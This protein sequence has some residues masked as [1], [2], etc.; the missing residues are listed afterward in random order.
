MQASSSHF[1][2]HDIVQQLQARLAQRADPNYAEWYR[3]NVKPTAPVRGVRMQDLRHLVMAWHQ[4]WQ[5]QQA[6]APASLQL[7]VTFQLFN[8]DHV[9]DRLAAMVFLD[10]VL[11]PSKVV[12]PELLP[13]LA[14]LF[15]PRLIS[16]FKACDHFA[17]KVLQPLL[18]RYG[19]QVSEQLRD[20]F[21]AD[22]VWQAR[23]AVSALTPLASDAIHDDLL[24]LGCTIVLARPEEE[25]KSIVGSAL[26]ALGKVR[27]ELVES[28][29]TNKT[30]LI[31]TNAA[32]LNK[33]TQFLEGR[34]QV[35]FREQ[36]RLLLALNSQIGASS[37]SGTGGAG[38]SANPPIT[39]PQEIPPIMP[40]PGERGPLPQVVYQESTPTAYNPID[41]GGVRLPAT[42]PLMF[43]QQ[44]EIMLSPTETQAEQQVSEHPILPS[45]R[46]HRRFGSLP[47]FPVVSSDIATH[48]E[49]E[50]GRETPIGGVARGRIT[51]SDSGM[52][53]RTRRS[54]MHSTSSTPSPAVSTSALQESV[55]EQ[56]RQ[57]EAHIPSSTG[58]DTSSQAGSTDQYSTQGDMSGR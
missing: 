28:F 4:D 11:I 14:T 32:C 27:P 39:F 15:P 7:E 40:L 31:N 13:R 55:G 45:L 35:Y 56:G 18:I 41:P 29:L 23:A 30:N 44:G 50:E 3:H 17:A 47:A 49:G 46:N 52:R 22:S 16:D 51:R 20:W 34:R 10:E 1:Q 6:N 2:S 9:D 24:F 26:R 38:P 37:T 36:R 8:A 33:A 54:R 19:S 48:V 21:S 12:T 43:R 25:A 57:P 58:G 5:R 42:R 53:R